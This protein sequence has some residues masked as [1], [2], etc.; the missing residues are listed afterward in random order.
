MNK[1]PDRQS[2]RAERESPPPREEPLGDHR[3]PSIAPKPMLD[4]LRQR[5]ERFWGH[6][7]ATDLKRHLKQ[8]ERAHRRFGPVSALRSGLG[9]MMQVL[10][11]KHDKTNFRLQKRLKYR[12]GRLITLWGDE[13]PLAPDDRLLVITTT[14]TIVDSTSVTTENDVLIFERGGKR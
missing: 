8:D 3:I 9:E 5:V 11:A 2:T 14:T 12:D 10:D 4:D 13:H 1:K 7:R 6:P